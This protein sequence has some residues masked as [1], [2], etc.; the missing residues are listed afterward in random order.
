MTILQPDRPYTFSDIFKLNISAIDL[1]PEYGYTIDRGYFDL[2]R[3]SKEL[4][5][6]DRLQSELQDLLP[7]VDLTSEQARRETLVAPIVTQ[8]CRLTRARL[9]IEQPILVSD[10]LQGSLDY[11]I[12]APQQ[13]VILEAK[14]DDLENGFT[15]LAVELIAID[16]WERSPSVE[17]QSHLLGAVTTGET[18]RFGRLDRAAKRIEQD[19]RSFGLFHDLQDLV[20]TLL[21]G[22]F[23]S[24]IN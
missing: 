9:S 20:Q 15:Q 5:F 18:W 2:P 14:K 23:G 3:Y 24:T 13:F 22:E 19:V 12:R 6:L 7:L 1:V 21:G 10:R 16:Q 11:L 4:P 17:L 8:I